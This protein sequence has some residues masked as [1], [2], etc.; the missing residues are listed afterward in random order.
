MKPNFQTMTK[1][2]LRAYVLAHRDDDEAFYAYVD[3][4][5]EANAV[6]YDA[7]FEWFQKSNPHE[8][9]TKIP[10]KSSWFILKDAQGNKMGVNVQI[11]Q[12]ELPKYQPF[13][14][15]IIDE[16]I[17][18][19]DRRK[20]NS[21]MMVFLGENETEAIRLERDL[22]EV[23]FDSR[24]QSSHMVGYIT[25]EGKFQRASQGDRVS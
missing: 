15:I 24:T 6:I 22:T 3:N 11:M 8:S 20:L 18:K 13:I 4:I 25:P 23:N 19:W 14:E 21:Y 16:L 17:N 2:E 10:S 12:F 1:K 9:V 7:V 5:H